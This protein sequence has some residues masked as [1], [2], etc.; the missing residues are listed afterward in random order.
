LEVEGTCASPILGPAG[1][2]EYFILARKKEKNG[3]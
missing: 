2:R 1:N 3:N